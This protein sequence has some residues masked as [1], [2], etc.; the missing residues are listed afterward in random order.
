MR[1]SVRES[2]RV[3]KRNERWREKEGKKLRQ[4]IVDIFQSILPLRIPGVNLIKLFFSFSPLIARTDKLECLS[5]ASVEYYLMLRPYSGSQLIG[6]L[7]P[8]SQMLD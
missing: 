8:H 5:A 7:L 4:K 3:R 2:E 6:R 1:E